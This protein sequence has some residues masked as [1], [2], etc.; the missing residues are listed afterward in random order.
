MPKRDLVN[1]IKNEARMNIVTTLAGTGKAYSDSF[2]TKDMKSI[3]FCGACIKSTDQSDYT[4]TD[5]DDVEVTV[6]DSDDDIVFADVDPAEKQLGDTAIT[7]QLFKVGAVATKRY[8][9]LCITC[10][11][12]ETL[13]EGQLIIGGQV[14]SEGY[15]NPQA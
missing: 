14:I 2:D 15:V 3:A 7:A 12:L 11:A 1:N 8:V 10:N 5:Y 4:P 13:T 9:R 6:Q